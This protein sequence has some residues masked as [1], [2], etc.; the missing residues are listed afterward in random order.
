MGLVKSFFS[1]PYAC[2]MECL[3]P[4]HH[5]KFL[6]PLPPAANVEESA[7]YIASLP[8]VS[9]EETVLVPR[10]PFRV[11]GQSPSRV[12]E[13]RVAPRR[14]SI[15]WPDDVVSGHFVS[16][17]EAGRRAAWQAIRGTREEYYKMHRRAHRALLDLVPLFDRF[18]RD[19]PR[20]FRSWST[21]EKMLR[22]CKLYEQGIDIIFL[23]MKLRAEFLSTPLLAMVQETWEKAAF[24]K[25]EMIEEA[26][27]EPVARARED[28]DAT[29]QIQGK[30]RL[31]QLIQAAVEVLAVEEPVAFDQPVAVKNIVIEEA[32]VEPVAR[33]REDADATPQVQ[34]EDQLIQAAAEGLAVEE[35]E[36]FHQPDAVEEREQDEENVPT[37]SV[38]RRRRRSEAELLNSELGKYWVSP[39]RR[40]R[41][42]RVRKELLRYKP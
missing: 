19:H 38:K 11:V 6:S 32:A 28:A 20:R 42:A 40:R 30:D 5:S 21:Y 13:N 24:N 36:A 26:A 14:R 12:V 18:K 7:A 35:S 15:H 9:E 16:K 25:A 22:E 37:P 10:P 1:L 29:P 33:A 31:D 27:V 4:L 41:D 2:S 3:M 8:L 39:R 23:E 17:H 34:G